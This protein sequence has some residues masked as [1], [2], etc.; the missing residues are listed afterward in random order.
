MSDVTSESVLTAMQQ[1]RQ[2]LHTTR[3][4]IDRIIEARQTGRWNAVYHS[5]LYRLYGAE[6]C[7]LLE[8]IAGAR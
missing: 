7:E 5:R 3:A 4:D 2:S 6:Y 1:R 8:I